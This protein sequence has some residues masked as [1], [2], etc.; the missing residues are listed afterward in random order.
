MPSLV[1]NDQIVVDPWRIVSK[2]APDYQE[3]VIVPLDQLNAPDTEAVW[4][5]AD[6][7]IEEIVNDLLDLELIAIEFE[8]FA[9]GRGL[10]LATLLRTRYEFKG[11]IRAFG[12]LQPD[13]TP[14]MKRSGFDSFVFE[15]AA[16]AKAALECMASSTEF[17]QASA[18]QP[19]PS[20]RRV[21]RT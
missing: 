9:D 21:K 12:E 15:D 11:E 18:T 4:L 20:Y 17:Y 10:S 6:V 14:F 13:L 16:M 1:K 19:E 2:S 8:T 3:K 5:S 7:E